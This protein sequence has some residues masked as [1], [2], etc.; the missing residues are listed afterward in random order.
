MGDGLGGLLKLY[1][2]NRGEIARRI[3]RSAKKW[4]ARCVVGYSE[5]DRDLPFVYEADEA[6]LIPTN[7]PREAYLDIGRI[8]ELA[9]QKGITHLHPGYGFLSENYH[10]VE[11]LEA[12]GIKFV[13]PSAQS[14][15]LLGDKLASR[16]LAKNLGLPLVDSYD[17]ADQDLES[18]RSRVEQMGLPVLIKPAAGGGGKG[19]F[20]LR[21]LK[22]L[23]AAHESAKRVAKSSFSDDRLYF[24]RFIE[25]ARHIEVQILADQHGNVETLGER[26]CSLQRRH[27][28]I[29]EEAPCQFIGQALREKICNYSKMIAKEAGYFSTGTV[30][31]IW[32]GQDE[33]YFLEVNTRLQVEHPVTES[34][35]DTD[36]VEWQLKIADGASLAGQNFQA[37]GHAIEVR[38]CAETPAKDFMPSG[39]KI[40]LLDLSKAVRIDFG[41][42]ENNEV[43]PYFDS[44]MG[45]FIAFGETREQATQKLIA[46]LSESKVLGPDTNRSY[47]IQLLK[48]PAF[49]SGDFHTRYLEEKPYRFPWPQAMTELKRIKEKDQTARVYDGLDYHDDLDYYSPWGKIERSS[50][51]AWFYDFG[52]RRYFQLSF[53]DW[54]EDRPRP[55]A[56]GAARSQ[57]H[58]DS[59]EIKSPMPAKVIKMMIA[60]GDQVKEGDVLL[61]LEAMKMEQKVKAPFDGLVKKLRC[62]EG[63]QLR[64]QQL[65]VEIIKA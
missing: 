32:D 36:L 9:K 31:W 53:V 37:S 65:I 43:S 13:G 57:N 64:P 6:Y 34:I 44:L 21:D 20:V 62:G 23:E 5:V 35:F 52:D 54:S 38:L 8:V 22:D 30:E 28:K 12:E 3:I 41:Y 39:G 29:V 33:V 24:E 11:A 4:G 15:K 56:R 19:M 10:F 7:E 27:Q 18:I 47:L 26:E 46:A 48:D 14:M 17:G 51:A 63:D 40:H 16:A 1:I 59:G 50:D 58:E 42:F 55:S 45:K 49:H 25:K 60:E 2:A 61:V